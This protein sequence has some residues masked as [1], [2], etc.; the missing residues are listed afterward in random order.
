MRIE[1]VEEP[2]VFGFTWGIN[3]LPDDRSAPHVRRVPRPPPRRLVVAKSPLS[4]QL[5]ED[6]YRKAFRLQAE[7]W[8][9]RD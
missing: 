5:P 2:T 4:V 6:G 8:G 3:G 7:G 9:E 1:R